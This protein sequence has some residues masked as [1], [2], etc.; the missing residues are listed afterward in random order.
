MA[1]FVLHSSC[2]GEAAHAVPRGKEEN[3]SHFY[4]KKAKDKILLCVGKMFPFKVN[5]KC[6]FETHQ[7]MTV[8]GRINYCFV[9]Y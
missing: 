5:Y 9:I 4:H 3:R 2:S 8:D 6:R 7:A 1:L